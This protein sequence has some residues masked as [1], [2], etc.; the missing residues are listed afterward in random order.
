MLDAAH[1]RRHCLLDG[2]QSVVVGGDRHA[3]GMRLLD[4][5][6]TR[7]AGHRASRC[8]GA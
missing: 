8:Y 5:G 1:A 7:T 3:E 4:T 6:A 2:G